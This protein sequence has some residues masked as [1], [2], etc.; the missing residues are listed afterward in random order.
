MTGSRKPIVNEPPFLETI[1][2]IDS[3]KFKP[4]NYTAFRGDT[5]PPKTIFE[6]GFQRRGANWQYYN[7]SKKIQEPSLRFYKEKG[8]EMIKA[9]DI[10]SSSAICLTR[11]F[12]LAPLFPLH[13]QGDELFASDYTWLY[14][15]QLWQGFATYEEQQ[16]L[17]LPISFC[18]EVAVR[19]VPSMD[20]IAAIQCKRYWNVLNWRDGM[21]YKLVGDIEWNPKLR[22]EKPSISKLKRNEWIEHSIAERKERYIECPIPGNEIEYSNVVTGLFSYNLKTIEKQ[23]HQDR[24]YLKYFLVNLIN[25]KRLINAYTRM[26]EAAIQWL[27]RCSDI[28]QFVPSTDMTPLMHACE[29]SNHDLVDY[30]LKNNA[31]ISIQNA[32]GKSAMSYASDN[33]VRGLLMIKMQDNTRTI[34][35]CAIRVK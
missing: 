5:R 29:Q 24:R 31:D 16:A 21:H 8:N 35:A 23:Q 14:V 15:V 28:N 3:N 27:A 9:C 34:S 4:L 6:F 7:E 10:V 20:V 22:N 33:K 17:K 1:A 13:P 18:Q 25:S 2:K 32:D 26:L 12:D 30:L 11:Q 19:D